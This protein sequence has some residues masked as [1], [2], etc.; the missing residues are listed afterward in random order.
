M[1]S[2]P[3]KG[4]KSRRLDVPPVVLL[5][6]LA[7]LAGLAVA[8]WAADRPSSDDADVAEQR[9][10]MLPDAAENARLLDENLNHPDVLG[11]TAL[12]EAGYPDLGYGPTDEYLVWPEVR[13]NNGAV[14]S[15]QYPDGVMEATDVQLNRAVALAVNP[16]LVSGVARTVFLEQNL[17]L[18]GDVGHLDDRALSMEEIRFL[19]VNTFVLDSGAV[20]A[21]PP[22]SDHAGMGVGS[23]RF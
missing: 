14:Q 18:P 8:S 23:T 9:T 1:Q 2:V 22:G 11:N 6:A 19:E 17:M 10:V 15:V 13:A 16:E 3:T 21:V 5:V 20:A 12:I 4:L 7:V